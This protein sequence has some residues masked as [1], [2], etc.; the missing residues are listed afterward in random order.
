M[1][2][3]YLLGLS[4]ILLAGVPTFAQNNGPAGGL[5]AAT[6]IAHV[7]KTVAAA[8]TPESRSAAALALSH[9]PTYDEGTAQR[10]REAALSYSDM[11]VRGGWPAIPA[12]AKFAIGVQGANDDLLR[13]RLIV[14]GDLAD[15]KS[16]GPYDDVLAEGVKRFQA[17]HGLAPTGI[18]TP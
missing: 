3:T 4:A 1:R 2:T 12:D 14:S 18:M 5:P 11:A 15:D 9:E 7:A 6:P 10:I 16:T 8:S 17:R 13:K